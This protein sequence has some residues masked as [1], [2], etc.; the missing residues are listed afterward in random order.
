VGVATNSGCSFTLT[1]AMRANTLNHSL[2]LTI[3]DTTISNPTTTNPNT[4]TFYNEYIYR[5]QG[6][7]IAS[8]G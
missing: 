1:K 5:F 3:T 8:G 2:R 7:G 6:A 4:Y